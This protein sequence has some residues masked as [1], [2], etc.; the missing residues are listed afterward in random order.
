[1]R[2]QRQLLLPSSTVDTGIDLVASLGRGIVVVDFLHAISIDSLSLTGWSL[3]FEEL[4]ARMRARGLDMVALATPATISAAREMFAASRAR[5]LPRSAPQQIAAD[6]RDLNEPVVAV[7]AVE[8][9]A[10]AR[11]ARALGVPLVAPDRV[12]STK[13]AKLGRF[14]ASLFL[15]KRAS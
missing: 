10:N 5:V 15:L 9:V 6:V 1:L 13:S 4:D 3:F 11:L 14:I 7:W 8:S 2:H 12:E